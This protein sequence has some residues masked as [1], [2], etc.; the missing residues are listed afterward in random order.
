MAR[1]RTVQLVRAALVN[2][3]AKDGLGLVKLVAHPGILG[4]LAREHEDDFRGP[5]GATAGHCVP[6]LQIRPQLAAAACQVDGTLGEVG[7]TNGGGI[8]EIAE[9]HGQVSLG[10]ATGQLVEGLR[11]PGRDGQQ[12]QVAGVAGRLGRRGA[13]SRMTWALVPLKPNELTPARRGRSPGARP[14]P[15]TGDLRRAWPA[16]SMCGFIAGTKWRCRGEMNWF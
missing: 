11:G 13:S 6:L 12:V 14:M 16:Q 4:P 8:A 10:V 9:P 1:R 2:D 7:T 3:R 15:S 5:A